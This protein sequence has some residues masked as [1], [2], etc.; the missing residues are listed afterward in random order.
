MMEGAPVPVAQ[1]QGQGTAHAPA[2]LPGQSPRLGIL[3]PA[4]IEPRTPVA[5]QTQPDQIAGPRG[6]NFTVRGHEKGEL[7]LETG[8]RHRRTQGYGGVG[9]AEDAFADGHQGQVHPGHAEK[10]PGNGIRGHG[11]ADH[12]FTAEVVL[13]DRGPAR[14]SAGIALRRGQT[15]GRT[16][17]E[18][19]IRLG[20]GFPAG[21][22]RAA[23]VAGRAREPGAPAERIVALQAVQ[24]RPQV[25]Q[26]R[27]L[28]V[29]AGGNRPGPAQGLGQGPGVVGQPAPGPRGR[30][31][32]GR[33]FGG[34]QVGVFQEKGDLG[35]GGPHLGL[36]G[37]EQGV[38]VP[39]LVLD[40]AGQE[41][42]GLGP[43]GTL[44]LLGDGGLHAQETLAQHHADADHGHGEDEDQ[45]EGERQAQTAADPVAHQNSQ[46]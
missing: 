19:D 25:R 27:D 14:T 32:P 21:I 42:G 3:R 18:V 17:Q 6:Q 11:H 41:L 39:G 31:F 43:D 1:N 24:G 37:A 4:Q 7:A 29:G 16:G 13:V 30:D 20:Q 23:D 36:E 15:E 44:V 34:V 9:A 28:D 10:R 38:E 2:H 33:G 22:G 46:V 40:R 8:A 12:G 45:G 35:R 26:G 5:R